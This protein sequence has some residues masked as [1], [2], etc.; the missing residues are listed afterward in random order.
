MSGFKVDHKQYAREDGKVEFSPGILEKVG[1]IINRYPQERRKSALLPV[2]YIAQEEFGGYLSVGTMDYVAAILSIQPVEVYEVATFYSQ[3]YLEKRGRYVIE[4]C[5][6]SPCA[7]CGGEK[8]SE[9]IQKK[10]N[11]ADGQTTSDGLFT[12]REVECLGACG[13]APAMQINTEF[14]EHLTEQKTDEI[15]DG[16]KSSGNLE[17]PN[18]SKWADRLF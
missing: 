12:L 2:L 6:T 13:Y 4:I 7:V 5:R 10:L 15:L 1:K 8:I 14:Y 11:I 17:E 3:F 16:L 18:D 9:Y